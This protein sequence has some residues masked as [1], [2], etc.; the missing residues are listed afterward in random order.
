MGFAD[1]VR[2]GVFGALWP[3]R[4]TEG[5]QECEAGF[6]R[7]PGPAIS[8]HSSV[9]NHFLTGWIQPSLQRNKPEVGV[10]SRLEVD[11]LTLYRK[12]AATAGGPRCLGY[13]VEG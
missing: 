12:E 8:G 10:G 4:R 6:A 3:E 13:G 1:D 2:M 11:M 7:A 5:R 9:W